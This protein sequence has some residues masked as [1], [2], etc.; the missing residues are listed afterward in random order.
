MAASDGNRII[1]NAAYRATFVIRNSSYD[2]LTSLA[3]LAAIISKDSG[4]T[5]ASTNTAVEIGTS[6]IVYLDF[7]VT[8]MT[9]AYA[10]HVLITATGGVDAMV[11]LEPE[12][13]LD[14]GV[15][16]AGAT[17]STIVLRAAA[18]A[19]N[20]L[21]AGGQIEIVRGTG[22][23]QVR[24]ILSYVGSSQTATIDRDWIT[25]PDTTSVYIIHPRVAS[26]HPTAGQPNVNT[27]Q[28]IGETTALTV[29]TELYNG[30]IKGTVSDAGPSTTDFTAA[31]G[32]LTATNDYYNRS[33]VVFTTGVLIGLMRPVDDYTS[34]YN[35]SFAASDAWPVAPG[36]GDEFVVISYRA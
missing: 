33:F 16:A 35:F 9:F 27:I 12:P 1:R 34:A 28:L 6:G 15:A 31:A 22:A 17:A 18:S 19:S 14:S 5:A 10:A 3:S 13:G 20:N 36:N 8:E 25:N 32:T 23:G 26:G 30:G 11:Y 24:T 21:Y 2:V 7:T 4:S 29:L